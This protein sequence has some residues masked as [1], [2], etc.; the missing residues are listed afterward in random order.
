MDTHFEEMQAAARLGSGQCALL[1]DDSHHDQWLIK[2]ALETAGR[3]VRLSTANSGDEAVAYLGGIG[4]YADRFTYPLPAVV[5]LDVK[6]PRRSGFEVLEWL[7][8]DG[9]DLKKVPVVMLSSSDHL[10][11]IR[12]AYE[13]GANGYVVKPG[14]HDDLKKAMDHICGYWL[15]QNRPPNPTCSSII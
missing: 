4:V 6:M 3:Q 2:R 14:N 11:D 15:D 7:R 8:H 5:L 1:V 10:R 9:G 12:H 13:Q